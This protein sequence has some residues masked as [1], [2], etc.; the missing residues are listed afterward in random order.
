MSGENEKRVTTAAITEDLDT[1]VGK[2]IDSIDRLGLAKNTI[3]IYMSDNGSG[4]G[5]GG[6]QAGGR[7]SGLHGGKGGVWEGGI[8]I[9]FII[10]GPGVEANS[11]SHTPIVGY[12]LFPTFCQ[13]ARID[14]SKLPARI[15]GGSIAEIVSNGGNGSVQRPNELASTARKVSGPSRCAIPNEKPRFQSQQPTRTSQTRWEE[16]QGSCEARGFLI[17]KTR[18]TL[19]PYE[20]QE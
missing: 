13:W 12:D 7:R 18:S 10:A 15:E 17:P 19:N 9:P 16:Q 4:G 8:R 11:W 1:G 14:R 6:G 3:I 2:V 5:G 20:E